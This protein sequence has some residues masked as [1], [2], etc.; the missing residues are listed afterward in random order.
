MK[1]LV[2]VLA[3]VLA[4]AMLTGCSLVTVNPEK[5]T[6]ATV[7]D[8]KITKAEYDKGF[9]EFLSSYGYTA[10]S[11]EI[12]DQIKD[13]KEMYLDTMVNDVIRDIKV[14]ELGFG[15]I[16]QAD[17]DAAKKGVED[18]QTEQRKL[19]VEMYTADETVTDP[20]AQADQRIAEYLESY[21]M[22][23]ET[24]AEQ[25]LAA[26]PGNRLYDEVT[27]DATVTEADLA[28]EFEKRVAEEKTSYDGDKSLFINDYE[29]GNDV[30]YMPEGCYYV[31]HI[32]LS[33]TEEQKK[34]ISELRA[35]DDEAVAATADAKRDEYLKTIE[36]KAN[37][38]LAKVTAGEDFDALI[39]QYGEDPGMKNEQFKG[40]YLTFSGDTNFVAE[41]ADA[42]GKLAADGETTGLV[43]TDFGY[44]IIRRVSTLATKAVT[45]DD[46]RQTLSEELLSTK[47]DELYEAKF[48]E[49]KAEIGVDLQLSK[50]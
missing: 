13:L 10:E 46:V 8:K 29:A 47:K 34:E 38:V 36:E 49:W 18:W 35:D 48:E 33:L 5:I 3:I 20:E 31:K 22:T 24:M 1:K 30:F 17:K 16:T 14:A 40:G 43:G 9:S 7:G 11:E 27:K 44:H 41:F 28:A 26:I 37:E 21:G 12:A 23:L 50:L 39:A 2:S 42:S 19:L 32:L 45:L 15:E 4:F 6:V 25:E